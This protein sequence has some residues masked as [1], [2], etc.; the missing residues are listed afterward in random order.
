MMPAPVVVSSASGLN[1]SDSDPILQYKS[2]SDLCAVKEGKSP[3]FLVLTISRAI[4]RPLDTLRFMHCDSEALGCL[5]CL[6]YCCTHFSRARALA[7]LQALAR[8]LEQGGEITYIA[9]P[10][11]NLRICPYAA[12]MVVCKAGRF[13][14]M[15]VPIRLPFHTQA[16]L[17]VRIAWSGTSTAGRLNGYAH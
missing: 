14:P 9:F 4:V 12:S 8:S 7:L 16:I 6:S 17:V 11:R 2:V 10:D 5:G 1:N 3:F 13:L 15:L